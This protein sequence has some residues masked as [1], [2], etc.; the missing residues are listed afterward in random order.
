[1]QFAPSPQG[2]L[3]IRC[4]KG[5]AQA[6]G[7]FLDEEALASTPA[8]APVKHEPHS[9]PIK[10]SSSALAPTRNKRGTHYSPPSTSK[11]VTRDHAPPASPPRQPRRSHNNLLK[12]VTVEGDPDRDSILRPGPYTSLVIPT[13]PWNTHSKCMIGVHNK[14][15]DRLSVISINPIRYQCRFN[16]YNRLSILK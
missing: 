16:R 12:I 14:V 3:H 10:R 5:G 13:S 11:E 4:I 9:P 8:A 1:M 6:L 2:P 15:G 7:T